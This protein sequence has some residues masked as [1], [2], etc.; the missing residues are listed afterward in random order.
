MES[1]VFGSLADTYWTPGVEAKIH[2]QPVLEDR[3]GLAELPLLAKTSPAGEPLA[4]GV[5]LRA[6]AVGRK[7]G[8]GVPLPVTLTKLRRTFGG[9]IFPR[10]LLA[11]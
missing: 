7:T 5:E 8:Y 10:G 4:G 11:I 1:P 2:G 6:Y 3:L 9:G